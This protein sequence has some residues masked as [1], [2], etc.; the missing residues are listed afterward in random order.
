MHEDGEIGNYNRG[1]RS[2]GHFLENALPILVTLPIGFKV[3]PVPSALLF[4]NYSVGRIVYQIGYT[5]IGF[6]AHASG[7]MIDRFSTF[8]MLSLV[9]IAG[10]VMIAYDGPPPD[11]L[12]LANLDF[13][14]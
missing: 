9:L 5:S 11:Q 14:N 8:T 7:F 4:I 6:G 12:G 10:V 3:F 13:G 1:N 2:I